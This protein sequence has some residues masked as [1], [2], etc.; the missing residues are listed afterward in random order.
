[1]MMIVTVTYPK[2][3]VLPVVVPHVIMHDF[4]EAVADV[5]TPH[6]VHGGL[7]VETYKNNQESKEEKII[8]PNAFL[9]CILSCVIINNGEHVCI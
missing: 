7:G 4:I 3:S 9:Y 2:V 6:H 1:M 5:I 8:F